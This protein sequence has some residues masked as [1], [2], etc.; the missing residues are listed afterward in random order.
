MLRSVE[1][2][3]GVDEALD[4]AHELGGGVGPGVDGEEAVLLALELPELHG[5]PRGLQPGGVV[6]GAVA[7]DVAPADH[8]QRRRE[9]DAP[10]LRRAGPERVGGGVVRRGALGQ[11]Q[12]P[13]PVVERA[14]EERVVGALRLRPRARRAAEEGHQLDVAADGDPAGRRGAE[15]HG[16]VVRDV[17][18]RRVAGD[19]HAAQVRRLGDP[20]VAA[21]LR[22]RGQPQ[23]RGGRVVDG[24]GEAVLRGEAVVRGDH[25]GAELGRQPEAVVLEVGPRAGPDAEPAAVVV[26]EHRQ[27]LAAAPGPVQPQPQPRGRVERRVLPLHGPVVPH[28]RR[29]PRRRAPHHGPV[30]VHE[31]HAPA[32]LH[33]VRRR[34]LRHGC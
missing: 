7:E 12:A 15:P 34:R 23:D 10:Q 5:L 32:L 22:L 2:A 16:E 33:H 4:D 26:E 17:A 24:G 20:R 1:A 8:D 18:P 14:V 6:H 21:R 25:D 27:L 9:L 3:V 11:R 13:V 31:Q 28:R 30:A 29:E 19:E